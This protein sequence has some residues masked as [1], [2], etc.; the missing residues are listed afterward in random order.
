MN[1]DGLS[2]ATLIRFINKGWLNDFT[3][4]YRLDRYAQEIIGMEGFGEKSWR[5]LWDAIQRSRSTTFERYLVAMD[6]PM[7][8]R[9]AS[10]ELGRQ[11]S[12]DI[13]TFEAAAHCGFNFTVLNDFG[14]TLHQNI[15]DWFSKEENRKLFGELQKFMKIQNTAPATA[16][17]DN[18]FYGKTVVATGKLASYSREG[19]QE[20][21]LTLGA[22]PGSSVSKNTDYLIAGEKAGS[23]LD[24][25][26]ALGITVLTEQEFEAM[27]E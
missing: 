24:K 13:D 16:G 7:I 2:A 8:G 25:A 4:I 3:D 10:R 5:R 26:K 6:I 18:P 23:K 9:T 17:T 1:I 22:K 14:E 27:L 20:K 11:F 15:H 12:G 19:I 21:L